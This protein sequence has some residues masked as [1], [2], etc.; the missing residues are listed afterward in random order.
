MRVPVVLCSRVRPA[1]YAYKMNEEYT[2]EPI[3]QALYLHKPSP[4][5]RPYL[6]QSILFHHP[7]IP[8]QNL[9]P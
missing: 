2:K 8:S 9:R 4:R 7:D 5:R 3:K 6:L 1:S